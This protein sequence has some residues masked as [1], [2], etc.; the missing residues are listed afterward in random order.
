MLI[1]ELVSTLEAIKNEYG[2][3]SVNVQFD[4]RQSE[5]F[6]RNPHGLNIDQVRSIKMAES[7]IEV[8][9]TNDFIYI[10]E[11]KGCSCEVEYYPDEK[12]YKGK[13]IPPDEIEGFNSSFTAPDKFTIDKAF[14]AAVDEYLDFM[15]NA[16]LTKTYE[17]VNDVLDDMEMELDDDD[18]LD[19]GEVGPVEEYAESDDDNEYED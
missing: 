6:I 8:N 14:H 19:Y 2:D 15:S 5:G 10:D 13:V 3:M 7:G 12:I 11:Y 17:A 16:K 18:D 9:I 4:I 1:S